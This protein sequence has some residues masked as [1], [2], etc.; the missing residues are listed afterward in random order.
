MYLGLQRAETKLNSDAGQDFIDKPA[1][2]QNLF[3]ST[4]T[5]TVSTFNTSSD[6]RFLN[7]RQFFGEFPA[8]LTLPGCGTTVAHCMYS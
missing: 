7:Q 4:M 3:L 8:K 5:S 6:D 1:T 2:R